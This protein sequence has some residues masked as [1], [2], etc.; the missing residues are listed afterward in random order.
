MMKRK[1]AS[2]PPTLK[3][4]ATALG[5]SPD[6]V[7]QWI[8]EGRLMIALQGSEAILMVAKNQPLKNRHSGDILILTRQLSKRQWQAS[9]CFALQ[10]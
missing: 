3:E 8:I 9:S 10:V 1:N 4:I 7:L 6:T 5:I 2:Q